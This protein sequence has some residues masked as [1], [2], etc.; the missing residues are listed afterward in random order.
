L[1]CD[2]TPLFE[3][4]AINELLDETNPPRILP[5]DP[6]ERARQRAWVEV[7][8]DM[9]SA[10]WD[11]TAAKT[12]ADFES[13][14]TKLHGVF[15]RFEETIREPYFA[16]ATFGWVDIAAAP[17]LHRQVLLRSLFDDLPK[18]KAWAE[19]VAE[20]PSV[21][22]GVREDFTSDYLDRIRERGSVVARNF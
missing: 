1:I 3:S 4:S 18:T 19:R 12:D 11:L 14:K 21:V 9:L 22:R 7:A 15:V 5:D 6:L 8:N 2:G 10:Q 13:A 17:A 16:G 20:R